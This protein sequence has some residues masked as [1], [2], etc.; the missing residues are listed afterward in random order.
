M[1][2]VF[3]AGLTLGFMLLIPALI[4][5]GGLGYAIDYYLNQSKK[6]KALMHVYAPSFTISKIK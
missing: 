6:R 1:Y 2:E 4:I 5:G 3:I